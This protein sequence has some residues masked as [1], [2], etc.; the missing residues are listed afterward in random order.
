MFKLL[1]NYFDDLFTKIFLDLYLNFQIIQQNCFFPAPNFSSKLR[2]FEHT[3]NLN[4][5]SVDDFRLN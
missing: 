1:H 4:V 3:E 2:Q 5:D